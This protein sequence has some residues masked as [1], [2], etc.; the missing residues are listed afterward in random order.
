MYGFNTILSKILRFKLIRKFFGRN[1]ASSN[2]FLEDEAGVV[3]RMRPCPLVRR[4]PDAQ[5]IQFFDM[6]STP[7]VKFQPLSMNF[8]SYGLTSSPVG[9]TWAFRAIF[10]P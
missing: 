7:G 4:K 2:R 9:R 5:S 10:G 3:A 6:S 1:G 8:R